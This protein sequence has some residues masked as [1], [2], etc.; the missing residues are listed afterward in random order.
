MSPEEMLCDDGGNSM[1]ISP[2][3]K[4][5]ELLEMP[6]VN[7][8]LPSTWKDARMLHMKEPAYAIK[9]KMPEVVD[10]GTSVQPHFPPNYKT[11]DGHVNFLEM[12][13]L[14]PEL[15]SAWKDSFMFHLNEPACAIKV[16]VP[17][18]VGEGTSVQ[19]CFLPNHKTMYG[20][21]ELL[22]M[23]VVDPELS[24]AWKDSGMLC[25]GEPACAIPVEVPEVVNEGTSVHPCFL[26]NHKTMDGYE[27]FLKMLVVNPE[28]PSAG[29]D[30]GMLC[31]NE[32]AYAI[33]VEVPEVLGEETSAQPCFPP[34]HKTIYGNEEL[35]E[36]PVVDPELPTAWKDSGMLCLGEPAFAI[37][38]EVPEVVNEGTSVQPCFLPNHKTMDGYEEFLKMLVVNPE[39][40][41][42]GKDSGMLCLNKPAYA[43]KV[44]VPEV[45]DEGTNVQPCFLPNYKTVDGNEEFL[46]MPVVNPER[47]S[48]WDGT[49]MLHLN[50]SAYA[51]KVK[52][53]ELAD[54]G[55]SVRPCCM[56]SHK[57]VDGNEESLQMPVVN[58][59]L[60]IPWEDTN[61][62]QLNE[63]AYG[64]KVEVP[65]VADEGNN[66]QPCFLPN[67]KTMGE[68]EE[69]AD[70]PVVNPELPSSWDGTGMLHLNEPAY[71]IKVEVTEVASEG[72][73]V[74]P[75][76]LQN[77]KTVDGN[78][79]LLEMP[80]VKH[81]LPNPREDTNMFHLNV[82][83]S[84][85]KVEVPEVVD[86]G[87]S[88]QPCFLPNHNTVD[89]NEELQEMPVVNCKLPSGEKD[90]GMLHSNKP[91]YAIKVEVADD[92]NVVNVGTSEQPCF[93]PNHPIPPNLVQKEVMC[94]SCKRDFPVSGLPASCDCK[95]PRL[96]DMQDKHLSQCE[97]NSNIFKEAVMN[98]VNQIKEEHDADNAFKDKIQ[99]VV[100]PGKRGVKPKDTSKAHIRACV[101]G[102]LHETRG[103]KEVFIDNNDD[104]QETG[105][106]WNCAGNNRCNLSPMTNDARRKVRGTLRLF[107]GVLRKLVQAQ[108][109]KKMGRVDAS[110]QL[111][112]ALKIFKDHGKYINTKKRMGPVPGVEVG[113]LFNYRVELDIIGLHKPIQ[114]GIDFIKLDDEYVAI[115][116]VA[117]GRYDNDMVNSDVLIYTGQGGNVAGGCK[118]LE[119]QKLERG[120][121]ALKNSID[122]KNLV[123]VIQGFKERKMTGG[124]R[125]TIPSY[126]YDGLYSVNRYWQESGRHGML[127]Y[128]F[129]L[130]RVPHQPEITWNK[131][132][133][134]K[135]SKKRKGRCVDDILQDKETP[136]CAEISKGEK[137]PI[138]AVN[139]I[140]NEKPPSFTYITE[141]IY[142]D[143]CR[144]IPPKGCD[145]KDGCLDSLRCACSLK[146]GGEIPYNYGGVIVEEKSLVYE[147]GPSCKCPPTCH[148]RVSQHGI[149]L[150]L[151]VFK[152]ESRGW[153]VR[154]LSSISCGSFVCEY[155][156][157]LLDDKEAEERIDNDGYL[158]DIGQNYN[159]PTLR[160]GLSALIPDMP[161][162][163]SD[164]V[165]NIGFTLDARIYGNV[166]RFVNHS[167]SPN[168]FAQN[169]LYDHEDK[170][171]PHIMFFA[172]ENIPPLQELTYH[173]NYTIGQVLDS[174]G[175]IKKKSCYCGSSEC[176]G[177]MY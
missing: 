26:P 24:T 64:I 143:W 117:S 115:S 52:V 151:D 100:S 13:V 54:E 141:V 106:E 62:F 89:G 46:D 68:N 74:Q 11:V 138:F 83:G 65:E 131:V 135:K 43:I 97:T 160:D 21:E 81:K 123:R 110:L 167:C 148:N 158:F 14:N 72:T 30:S 154:C 6:L 177:R 9:V 155:I 49:V 176:T 4:C 96:G 95:L 84:A 32:P 118:Q 57:T 111:H 164:V 60:P 87:T 129:E 41:S 166:G 174:E 103:Q 147:C 3:V 67:H 150:P 51:T 153:G 70:M 93:L 82:P 114:S 73:I 107:H 78:E 19:P 76:C 53:T 133:Q 28:L 152:T 136:I 80:V 165:E 38:V 99:H 63:S 23:A 10:E 1:L 5:E 61:M 71:A 105:V 75:C 20:N 173:Y 113:D 163:C 92:P 66:V 175:N 88:V 156:G 98:D 146:N 171:I 120:N 157:E 58:H 94:P 130:R 31:L 132:K 34:N 12:P 37:P 112:A 15:P 16:E 27:E 139:T 161:S 104:E 101:V 159:D 2:S 35:L 7:P 172:A 126:I 77:Q 169:V 79:E 128:K 124:V 39:L 55:T 90:T 44:E 140:D 125:T 48:S 25:L 18:V 116:I 40:P 134:S 86:E 149:K 102:K 8:K 162:S 22:E 17:E 59:E 122:K 56:Q 91:A 119:D 85:I 50:E 42:A 69:L 145:C 142:P 29:K 108:E 36:M 127:I 109:K 144:P 33:K 137:T 170:R 45:A 47:P 121:L 168:L